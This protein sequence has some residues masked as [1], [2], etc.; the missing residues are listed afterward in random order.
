MS[1]HETTGQMAQWNPRATWTDDEL[2]RSLAEH[3]RFYE[4]H[5]IELNHERREI[6]ACCAEVARRVENGKS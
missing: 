6:V 3:C 4:R 1:Q 2:A 5:Q